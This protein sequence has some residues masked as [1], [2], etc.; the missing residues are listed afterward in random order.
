MEIWFP[1]YFSTDNIFVKLTF[2]NF[3]NTFF[4][5][6]LTLDSKYM[7]NNVSAIK[8]NQLQ[9]C[10]LVEFNGKFFQYNS[11]NNSFSNFQTILLNKLFP[12]HGP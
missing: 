10:W 3:L 6:F 5:V 8:L 1:S 7:K 11:I 2:Y 9:K 12:P 4:L